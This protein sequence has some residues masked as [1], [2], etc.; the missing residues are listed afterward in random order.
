[1][2]LLTNQL[3]NRQ[4]FTLVELLVAITVLLVFVLAYMPLSTFIAQGSQANRARL[5]AGNLA[6]NMIEEIRSRSY[7]EV[8]VQGGNPAGD[9]PPVQTVTLD[10]ITYTVQTWIN[11]VDDP[12]GTGSCTGSGLPYDYKLVRVVVTAQGFFNNGAAVR[13]AAQTLV[14]RE[15]EQVLLPGGN[16]RAC[17]VRGWRTDAAAPDVPVESVTV[18]LT[19]GPDAPQTLWTTRYGGA[20]FAG[21][22]PGTYAVE[23]RPYSLGMIPQPD[24]AAWQ[25]QVAEGSTAANKFEVE[26]PARLRLKLE[27]LDHHPVTGLAGQM[28]LHLDAPYGADIDKVLTA[29]QL[30]ADGRLPDDLLPPLWPVGSGYPGRYQLAVTPDEA[31]G[32]LFSRVVERSH[33]GEKDWDGGF[34]GPG[35]EKQLVIYL[36]AI[37]SPPGD[38]GQ[39]AAIGWFNGNSHVLENITDRYPRNPG[40]PLLPVIFQPANNQSLIKTT[41]NQQPDFT[42]S[43][44]FWQQDLEIAGRSRLT[45]RS[46]QIVF[47]GKVV[48]EEQN[49]HP[50]G[51]LLL[52]VPREEAA[53][54]ETGGLPGPNYGEVYFV[55]GVWRGDQQ[56]VE[57]GAY[58]WPDGFRL[59]A[60]YGKTPAQGGLIRR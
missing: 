52:S 41:A 22:K 46:R 43:A 45:L 48:L 38:A 31:A 20:V 49:N 54:G 57:P 36:A 30:Q 6:D 29:G 47:K 24:Q 60:D 59:P 1:M 5:T 7:N 4:G 18:E 10:G 50:T 14:A 35:T 42:A 26:Y 25:A 33:D 8:G 56:I 9:I 27:D 23:V 17:V 44:M 21:L 37:P 39:A 2:R 3:P 12:A 53:G 16:I 11:W 58:Y 32:Y 34:A 13:A 19:A 51:E 28:L 55:K 40:E 15:G